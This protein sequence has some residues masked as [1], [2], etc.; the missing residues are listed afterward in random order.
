MTMQQLLTHTAGFH[1][2]Y[3]QADLYASADLDDFVAKL[4]EVPLEF[5]P[6]ARWQYSVAYEVLGLVIQRL[7]GQSCDEYLHDHMFGPL[8]MKDTFLQVPQDKLL[9]LLPNQYL[10]PETG[11]ALSADDPASPERQGQLLG[12]SVWRILKPAGRCAT[13]RMCRCIWWRRMGIHAARLRKV[14]R[15]NPQQWCITCSS[16]P[17][18]KD[19]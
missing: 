17:E 6:G 2:D 3:P 9:R 1:A 10:E 11:K 8:H 13:S 12:P 19:G 14:C 5:E 15:G 7:S 16:D 4:A 18:S